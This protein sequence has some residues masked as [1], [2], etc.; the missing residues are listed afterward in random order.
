M[1]IFISIWEALY[2][3]HCI[4]DIES[5]INREH[6]LLYNAIDFLIKFLIKFD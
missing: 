1:S 5:V 3:K 2:A 6:I 4:N